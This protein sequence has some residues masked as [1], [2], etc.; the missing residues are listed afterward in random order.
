MNISLRNNNKMN[1]HINKKWR[2]K[3]NCLI[4]YNKSIMIFRN[5]SCKLRINMQQLLL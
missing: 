1:L 4:K 2:I 3:T 5:N